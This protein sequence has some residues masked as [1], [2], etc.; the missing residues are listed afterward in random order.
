[1]ILFLK[2]IKIAK[3][4]SKQTPSQTLASWH[5]HYKKSY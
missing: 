5:Y 1:V 3:H 4:E 2:K